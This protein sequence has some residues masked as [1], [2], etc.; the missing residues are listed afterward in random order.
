M[1]KMVML[2]DKKNISGESKRRVAV[3]RNLDSLKSS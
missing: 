3:I 2:G 1:A